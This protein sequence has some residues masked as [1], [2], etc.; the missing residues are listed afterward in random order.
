MYPYP[1]LLVCRPPKQICIRVIIADVLAIEGVT[2]CQ[3]VFLGTTCVL[4]AEVAARE[5][6]HMYRRLLHR[7][8][9]EN[10]YLLLMHA[11]FRNNCGTNLTSIP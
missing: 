5:P 7:R 8:S 9:E 2:W 11:L 4:E 1:R 3:E 6:W 10:D